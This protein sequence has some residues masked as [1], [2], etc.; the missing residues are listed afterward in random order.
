M[1]E[2][3]GVNTC[4]GS[5]QVLFDVDMEIRSGEMVALMGRNG[6]GKTTTIRSFMGLTPVRSGEI[7]FKEQRINRLPSYAVARM[8]I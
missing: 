1:L 7:I 5:S 3:K 6:M 4:Y 2:L 8:G